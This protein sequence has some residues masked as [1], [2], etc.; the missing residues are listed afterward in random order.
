MDTTAITRGVSRAGL[1]LTKYSPAIMTG[2][3]IVGTGVATVLACKQTLKAEPIL[4][5][6]HKGLD[7]SNAAYELVNH[8]DFIG[9]D[10]YTDADK[11]SDVI[12]CYRNAAISFL[13]L[14]AVPLAIGAISV[15]L[16]I[17]GQKVM[18]TRNAGLAVAFE[19]MKTSFDRYRANV[20]EDRGHS[21]DISYL[22]GSH[23]S[24]EVV[25]DE[26]G[27]EST[28]VTEDTPFTADEASLYARWFDET[29]PNYEDSADANKFFLQRMQS[30]FNDKLRAHGHVFL[31]E[32][33]DALGFKRTPAGSVVGWIWNGDGDGY[34]DF[35]LWQLDPAH[36]D[37]VNA[38]EK[39]VLLD[40]NVDG[41]IHNLI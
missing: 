41:D 17:S 21:R 30:M 1:L 11:R 3:G 13:K 22:A 32:V 27:V 25:T 16:L 28:K 24:E 9:D 40:F 19:T 2:V 18:W 36:K 29:N 7:D 10:T 35:G 20:V 31:N 6:F 12:L 38:W 23:H 15:G 8:P 4:D 34:I 39:C 5:K 14:Y 33:Y 37:F 26:N